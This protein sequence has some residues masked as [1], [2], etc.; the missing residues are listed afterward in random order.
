MLSLAAFYAPDAIPEELFQQ[1]PQCYPPA[2][3]G[4]ATDRK[5]LAE[6]M[7]KLHNLSLI[8]FEPARRVFSVHRLAQAAAR[9]A[10]GAAA[11]TWAESAL[12]AMYAAFPEPEPNTW[13]ACERLVTHARAVAA[14]VTTDSR[15]LAYVLIRAGTYLGE[16]AA[17][18]DVLPLYQRG[19]DAL[20]RLAAADPGN[21]GWQRDLSVAHNKIGDVLVAQG[22]LAHQALE[23]YRA[24]LDIAERLA[25]A[26]PGNAGWQRDLSVSHNKIGDVLRAQGNL[27]QALESYRAAL[28]IRER[29]AGA[30]PG[31]A[32]WQ[33]DLSVSHNKIGDVLVAQ[34]NLAQALESY[35][36]SM[37][38]AERLAGADPGNAGWQRD[39]IV[40]NVK[41]AESA[42][43]AGSIDVA[44][45]H[46]AEALPAI[47]ALLG[48]ARPTTGPGGRVDGR[49]LRESTDR[50]V[51]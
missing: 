48:G 24:S 7:G 18:G 30:D 27:A 33:R 51:G 34:G 31:N 23:S 4:V 9:D 41:L 28:D 49:R 44:R 16:R 37:D 3:A 15:E 47:A 35:R 32:G 6:A 21:A 29:L 11:G 36:A 19:K 12:R 46:Y 20:Q 42:Q 45:Q 2:L 40:S 17:L 10:L 13:P 43:G 1:P 26:D 5:A 14:H 25:G 38:I 22:N 8:D 39:L 50:G